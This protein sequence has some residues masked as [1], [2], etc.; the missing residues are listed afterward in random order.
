[1]IEIHFQQEEDAQKLYSFL[2]QQL[3]ESEIANKLTLHFEDSH[4]IQ[5]SN[6]EA[7]QEEKEELVK[8]IKAAICRFILNIKVNDWLRNILTSCFQYHDEIEQQQIMDIVH[9]VLEGKHED[10]TI[11]LPEFRMKEYMEARVDEWLHENKTF[12][13]DSF[14]TFRLRF[15]MNELQKYIE[16]S[17]DEYKM[18]QEYQMFIQTLREFLMDR[19]SKMDCLHLY[20]G[21]TISFYD[22]NFNEIKRGELTKM[23][24]RK[25]LFNHPIYIDSITIVP[26]LSIAPTKIH[27]YTDDSD[28]PIIRTIRNIFEERLEIRS[29]KLFAEYHNA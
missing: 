8:W 22:E 13:F 20:F 3:Q 4:I 15:F 17:L 19:D 11:F 25:L 12:S 1:M 7:F 6:M 16:L 29:T 24:D 23:V 21:E 2:K 26:L 28:Q 14:V 9:T 18:E 5:C 10:L 27:I